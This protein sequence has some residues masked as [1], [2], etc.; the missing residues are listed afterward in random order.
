MIIRSE[1]HLSAYKQ[2]V[3]ISTQILA[4][5]RDAVAVGVT[6][7]ELDALADKLCEENKV[8]PNFKG[9]GSP[10]NLYRWAMCIS[11]ND[12]VVH[13]IPDT[14]PLQKGDIV[15]L[16]FGILSNGYNTD[17]CVTVVVEKFLNAA[18]ENLVRVARKAVQNAVKLAVAGKRTGDLGNAMYSTARKAGYDVVKEFVGHGI[19]KTLHEE[20][21]IAAYGTPHSGQ[22]L[23]EGMVICVEAQVVAGSDEVYID[24]S[25]W[26]VKTVDGEKSA[27][28]E[29]MVVVGK[30][31]PLVL[32]PTLDWPLF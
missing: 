7:A 14:V 4:A 26:T 25:G 16:D 6:P 31:K 15:K 20:P 2:A 17:Q 30:E 1:K 27:M 28:F 8:R 13:G 11:V 22:L 10:R 32:T 21:Q 5:V 12:V 9:Q 29:Y 18:D 19:G 23:K 3:R 24:H